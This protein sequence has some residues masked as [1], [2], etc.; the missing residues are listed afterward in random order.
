MRCERCNTTITEQTVRVYGGR[1]VPCHRQRFS[2]KFP[3]VLKETLSTFLWIVFSPFS[4]AYDLLRSLVGF[5]RL[6][7]TPLPFTRREVIAIIEPVHGR[8]AA[9]LYFAGLRDGYLHGP[10]FTGKFFVSLGQEDGYRIQCDLSQWP[11]S[12]QSR[13]TNPIDLG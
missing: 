10:A 7:F 5:V 3:R 9:R 8:A 6:W 2:Q 1:C 4:F 11:A 13:A 12:V